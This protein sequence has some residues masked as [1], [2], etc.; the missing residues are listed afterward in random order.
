MDKRYRLIM[1]AVKCR[2]CKRVLI[3]TYAHDFQSCGHIFTDGGIE[4][5]RRGGDLS[6]MQDL[7][8]VE[9]TMNHIIMR[10]EDVAE[11]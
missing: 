4:Y 5:M 11:C 6:Q 10:Y 9:D 3:S 1:N 2:T 8:L 7:S